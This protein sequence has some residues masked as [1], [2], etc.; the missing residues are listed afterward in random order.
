MQQSCQQAL[1]NNIKAA[2]TIAPK[3]LFA[4][5]PIILLFIASLSA[6]MPP[7]IRSQKTGVGQQKT[8]NNARGGTANQT[9]KT[10]PQ[11]R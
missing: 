5:V 10:Q 1:I 3:L 4:Y 11:H 7:R 2:N 9:T 8:L 6:P